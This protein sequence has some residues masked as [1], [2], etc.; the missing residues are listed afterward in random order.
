MRRRTSTVI[1]LVA[2]AI[3]V[4]LFAAAQQ[5]VRSF[6]ALNTRLK[7]GDTVWVTDAQGREIKGRITSLAADS[8]IV[9]ADGRKTLPATQVRIVENRRRDSLANGAIIGM[10]AGFATAAGVIIADCTN[11]TCPAGGIVIYALL[12]GGVGAGVGVGVDA[13]IPGRRQVVYRAPSSGPSA[14][15]SIAPFITPRTKGVAVAFSF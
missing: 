10:V 14:R 12:F 8:L 2:A 5:P 6:D 11:D 3:S 15:L 7:P 13:A 9:D 1:V 4:P